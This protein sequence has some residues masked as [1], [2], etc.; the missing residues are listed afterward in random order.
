MLDTLPGLEEVAR[1][2][3]AASTGDDDAPATD[4]SSLMATLPTDGTAATKGTFMKGDTVRIVKGDLE[5]LTA[6]VTGVSADGTK[7]TAVPDIKGFGEEVEF[8][9]DELAKVFEVG[10]IT[11]S[12]AKRA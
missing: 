3:A 12:V 9:M 5:N 11:A 7:V 4:L 2:N 1:F 10:D 6:R 8:D